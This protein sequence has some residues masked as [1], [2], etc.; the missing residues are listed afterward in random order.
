MFGICFLRRSVSGLLYGCLALTNNTP[1]KT[2][3]QNNST[4][5]SGLCPRTSG[6]KD[7]ESR[8]PIPPPL[9]PTIA[10]FPDPSQRAIPH[11]SGKFQRKTITAG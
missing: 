2:N 3:G 10:P 5:C 6:F 11:Q 1:K 8:P 9:H 7:E 4:L